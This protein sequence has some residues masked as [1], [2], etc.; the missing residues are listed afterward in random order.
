MHEIQGIQEKIGGVIETVNKKTDFKK[1]DITEVGQYICIVISSVDELLKSKDIFSDAFETK[2]LS[3]IGYRSYV[4]WVIEKLRLTGFDITRKPKDVPSELWKKIYHTLQD[5]ALTTFLIV[6]KSYGLVDFSKNIVNKLER[7][8]ELKILSVDKEDLS[9]KLTAMWA[10]RVFWGL[11]ED[12][13]YDY[14]D[15]RLDRWGE[16]KSSFRVRKK[17]HTGG[18]KKDEIDYYYTIKRKE[19]TPKNMKETDPRDCLENEFKIFNETFDQFDSVLTNFWLR[20]SRRKVKKRL[21]YAL[22][23]QFWGKVHQVKFDID[24]YDQYLD[25]KWKRKIPTL[26][27]IECEDKRLLRHLIVK[28]WLS[29]YKTLNKGSRDLFRYYDVYDE[30]EKGYEV[31]DGKVHWLKEFWGG[32]FNLFKKTTSWS[33]KK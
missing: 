30:Y 25:S 2:I 32:V 22:D 3:S 9:Q 17:T 19:E 29:D 18:K 4:Y 16:D 31:K 7:E 20:K 15:L 27:E 26:L 8:R 28:L 13:Y 33:K 10:E 5:R 11:V 21:S 14:P 1:I 12:Q 6:L 24:D 23:Y